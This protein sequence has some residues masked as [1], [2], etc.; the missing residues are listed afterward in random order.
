MTLQSCKFKLIG[1]LLDV[2]GGLVDYEASNIRNR[3]YNLF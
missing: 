3:F 2:V 1:F